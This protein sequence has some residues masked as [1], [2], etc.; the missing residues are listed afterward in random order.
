VKRFDRLEFEPPQDQPQPAADPADGLHDDQYWLNLAGNERREGH[1]ENALRYYSRVLELNKSLVTGWLGQVQML[2]LLAEH[3]EAELWSRKAL[4]L[5]RKNGDLTAARAQALSRLQRFQEA[6]QASDASMAQ[7]GQSAYRWMVRGEALL[8]SGQEVDQH[9]FT[10]AAQLDP[11]WLVALEI[12]QIQQYYRKPS[13]AIAYFRSATEKAP[14]AAYC[15][16]LQGGCEMEM[17]LHNAA[18]SSFLK[19]LDLKPDHSDARRMLIQLD[20]ERWSIGRH[21]RRIFRRG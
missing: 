16:Y 10:K 7:E 11:D 3:K 9:C 14:A 2:V 17:G 8:A 13:R 12:G 18:K 15:W 4:E 6:M 20:A 19:C 21:L 1:F 5:F